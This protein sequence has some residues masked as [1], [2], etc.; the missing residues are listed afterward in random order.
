LVAA[1]FGP[2]HANGRYELISAARD[3]RDIPVV[4]TAFTE[5]TPESRDVLIEVVFLDCGVSPH[6]THQFVL[7]DHGPD[8]L[9]EVRQRIERLRSKRDPHAIAPLEQAL[10]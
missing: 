7:V 1:G 5:G 4:A 3:R 9:N 2:A 10:P 8:V 6:G